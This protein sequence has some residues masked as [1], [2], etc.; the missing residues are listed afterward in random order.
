MPF[1]IL[2]PVVENLVQHILDL[3]VVT[4]SIAG[5]EN[6]HVLWFRGFRIVFHFRGKV[7]IPFWFELEVLLLGFVV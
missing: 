2:L 5:R 3:A 6:N 4:T 7:P 1:A